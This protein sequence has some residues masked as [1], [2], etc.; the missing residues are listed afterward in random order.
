MDYPNL[1]SPYRIK[2]TR[3]R[4]RIL[5]A[6]NGTKHKTYEGFPVEFEIALYE[7]RAKGGVAQVTTGNTSV[8]RKY[9]DLLP[10]VSL[11]LLDLNGQPALNEVALSVRRSGAVP[12][13]ELNH[14]GALSQPHLSLRKNPIGPM[15]FIR[16]DGVEVITMDDALIEEAVEDFANAALYAKQ[17]SF[18]MCMVHGGHGWLIHSFLSPLTNKRTDRY[19]GSHENRARFAIEVCDRIRKNCGDDFLIEFRISATEF[20]EGGLTVE[21]AIRFTKLLEDKID[22]I[23]VSAAGL[24][25]ANHSQGYKPSSYDELETQFMSSPSP[26]LINP[27]G[28]FVEFAAAVKRSGVKIPVV[29]VGAITTPELAESI[30]AEGKADFVALARALIADPEFPNKARRG[31]RELITPCIRCERCRSFQYARQCSVN[32]REGRYQ[33]LLYMNPNPAKRKVAVIGGGPGGMQAAITAAERGHDVTLFERAPILGGVLRHFENEYLKREIVAY[34]NSQ[35]K[36]VNAL[37]KVLLN[38][39]ATPA[40]LKDGKYDVIIT[41][42]GANEVIP[43]IPG[44][45]GP[46][47][48]SA[49]EIEKHGSLGETI[50]I[51]GGGMTGCETAY[52]LSL[53]GK[54]ITL[55]ESLDSLFPERDTVSKKYSMPVFVRISRDENI[56]I[57]TGT[58]CLSV[59]KAGV[60]VRKP[61]GSEEYIPADTVIYSVGLSAETVLVDSLWDCAPDIIPVGDC[62]KPRLIFDAVSE[63]FFAAMNIG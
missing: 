21:D 10:G 60:S 62:V 1:F 39:E 7:A 51:I 13:V 5:N 23:H 55:V 54:R 22:L 27:A 24:T 3:F 32:P 20:I 37:V 35:I 50:V 47:V 28:Q 40:L 43:Q 31:Q 59:D 34:R 56:R 63:G 57:L 11:N 29:A 2:N 45:D 49:L 46:N 14:P 38:T 61:D 53:D 42:A 58:S 19:G 16:P 48:C 18:E 8:T 25:L 15:G 33:R 6:P 44:I 52:D 30:I 12:S 4:N 17:C 41:A 9:M 36:K 26:H